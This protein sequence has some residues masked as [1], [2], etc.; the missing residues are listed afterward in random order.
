MNLSLVIF[1]LWQNPMLAV[2]AF[3]LLGA[4]TVTMQLNLLESLQCFYFWLQK[5]DFLAVFMHMSTWSLHCGIV[6][7]KMS[8]LCQCATLN[9]V[10]RCSN[11]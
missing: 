11:S 4:V 10:W 1:F 6:G 8:C 7:N 5:S 3:L 9:V 2:A